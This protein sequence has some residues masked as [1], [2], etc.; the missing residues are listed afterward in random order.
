MIPECIR[1][2]LTQRRGTWT[3]FVWKVEMSERVI[4]D[5]RVFKFSG[6]FGFLKLLMVHFSLS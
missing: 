2:K 4:F 5:G 3:C 6:V 1:M